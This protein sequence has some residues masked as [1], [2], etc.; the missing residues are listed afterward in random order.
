ML[1]E[2]FDE[3]FGST[4][5]NK[6]L[7]NIVKIYKDLEGEIRSLK[8]EKQ[9][10]SVIVAEVDDKEAKLGDH[11]KR[12]DATKKKISDID[13]QIEPLKQ[14]I[15]EVQQLDL[16]YKNAQAEEGKLDKNL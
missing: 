2:R 7:E 16:E 15:E 8:I 4:R 10:F 11:R 14:K 1:K 3:I 13:N 9:A 5:F 6:A 12:L